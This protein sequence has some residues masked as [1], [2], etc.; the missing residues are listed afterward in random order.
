[1]SFTTGKSANRLGGVPHDTYGMTSLSIRQYVLGVYKHLGLREKDVTKVQTGGPGMWFCSFQTNEIIICFTCIDGDLGS[2]MLLLLHVVFMAKC[3]F[4]DEILLSS[5]KTIA[6]ID[7]SGVLADS[8]G[9]DR[10]EL[11]RLAKLRKPV[12][13][14]D[15]T[16]L[17]KE[18]YLVKVEDQDV[19]LPCMSSVSVSLLLLDNFPFA[20]GEIVL[21]GTDF[22]NSAHLRFKADMFVPCGGRP[23]AVNISNVSALIDADGK[24]HF[25]YIVEGANLFLTQ[26][27]RL[28]LEKRKVIL[29]KDSSANKGGVTSSSLEVLAGLSLTTEE[30]TDL[31]IFKD[32]KPS[33]FYQSYVTDIQAKITENAANEFNCIWKEHARL[34]GSKT[35]TAISDELSQT[36][37]NLQ[38]ELEGSDLFE[39]AP[40]RDGVLRRAI[41][42]TLVDRI[43]L[44]TLLSRLPESYQRALFSS[45]VASHFVRV[46]LCFC[47]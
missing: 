44:E 17:S 35:R 9:I 5:D 1:M 11:V 10:A 32:G 2:S 8:R 19:K 18:G 23:E 13:Y 16:K 36:L 31:M 43:G 29:F 15:T 25:K 20:A 30:Y 24:P 38:A 37:N 28:H 7:G 14:F 12:S 47:S 4:S 34:Q 40:S 41:P 46:Y 42:K 45:W 26:Q 27:A 6:V 3:R 33:E 21:D 39:D 22:R